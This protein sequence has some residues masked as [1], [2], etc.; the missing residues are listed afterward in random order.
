LRASDANVNIKLVS[1]I[2]LL[3]QVTIIEEFVAYKKLKEKDN[4]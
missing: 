3:T 2:K 1:F 4:E